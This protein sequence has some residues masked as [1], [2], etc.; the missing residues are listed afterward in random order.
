MSP[1]IEWITKEG[2][3]LKNYVGRQGSS[4]SRQRLVGHGFLVSFFE[5]DM[6]P[7]FLICMYSVVY[8][9]IDPFYDWYIS[10][11]TKLYI[12]DRETGRECT[13]VHKYTW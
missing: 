7:F 13:Y 4:P 12:L 11:C 5:Y 3:K 6:L 1:Y 10:V 9:L 2:V 8:S